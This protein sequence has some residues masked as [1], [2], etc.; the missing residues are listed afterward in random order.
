METAAVQRKAIVHLVALA[1]A[2][3]AGARDFGAEA[4]RS[5]LRPQLAGER[6]ASDEEMSALEH[7]YRHFYSGRYEAAAEAA[8]GIRTSEPED[9]AAYELRTSAL[10]FQIRRAMGEGTDKRKAL[11]SCTACPALLTQFLS[12]TQE[13]RTL[14]QTRLRADPGDD[15]AEFF[16]G[17]LDLNYIWLQLGTLGRRTGWNE[18]WE[19]RRSLDAVLSRNPGHVRARIA[20]AWMDYIVDTRLP[21]GTKWLLGGG[22]R[23]RALL[24]VR[25]AAGAESE[26]FVEI[27][28]S[29][30]L[31]EMLVRERQMPEA[32]EVAGRLARDFPD[33]QD[34]A[35]FLQRHDP[36]TGP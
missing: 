2:L 23:K 1:L 19:A 25:A 33:N 6:R 8:L 15:A 29:F 27:E 11:A 4:S 5:E 36:R 26:F 32:I 16:L 13:G 3:A 22:D 12:D 21:F 7:G 28:A 20:R 24:D 10:H 17:K 14:A 35:S 9:L 30:A 31:W 34:L 18:F